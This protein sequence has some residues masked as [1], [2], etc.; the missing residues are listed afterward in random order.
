MEKN[1]VH[2]HLKLKKNIF[3]NSL[4]WIFDCNKNDSKY[5]FKPFLIY[6]KISL[7]EPRI[8]KVIKQILS[9]KTKE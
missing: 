9:I 2:W 6:G 4:S 3:L 7:S 5:S 1:E 8:K